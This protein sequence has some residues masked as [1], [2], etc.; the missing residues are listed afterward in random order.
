M[1]EIV[2]GYKLFRK[3]R[4]GKLHPLFINRRQII[5]P[6]VWYEAEGY[7][8]PGFAYR[9]GWH[10]T[11]KPE[12]PHLK[13]VLKSGEQRVWAQV[14]LKDVTEYPRPE[15]QGGTWLLAKKLMVMEA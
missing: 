9:P 13:E 6:G 2:Y 14:A 4:N 3:D 5:T 12:A 1:D 11:T 15:S 10:A 8:T 7:L